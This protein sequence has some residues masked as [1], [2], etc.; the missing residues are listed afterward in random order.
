MKPD[1]QIEKGIEQRTASSWVGKR[2]KAS[3]E[4]KCLIFLLLLCWREMKSFNIE[5]KQ[6]KIMRR[7]LMTA[8][9]PHASRLA[10][11]LKHEFCI[12][13]LTLCLKPTFFTPFVTQDYTS[14]HAQE[15]QD[16]SLPGITFLNCQTQLVWWL[17]SYGNHIWLS[18]IVLAKLN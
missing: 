2:R 10:P 13:C 6:N 8:C 16:V 1:W 7:P 14:I 3:F 9:N 5:H 4:L 15:M 12:V 11:A 18:L 17:L